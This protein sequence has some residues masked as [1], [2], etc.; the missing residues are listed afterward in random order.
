MGKSAEVRS[1]DEVSDVGSYDA[2][3]LGSGV[4]AG[5]W[6]KDA[7]EWVH[8]VVRSPEGDFRDWAAIESW[9]ASIARDL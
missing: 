7:R 1:I 3:V 4:Y 9:A 8:Q 5:S 6:L 2:F